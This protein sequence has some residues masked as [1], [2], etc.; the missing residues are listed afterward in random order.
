MQDDKILILTGDDILSILTGRELEIIEI[1]QRAYETHAKGFSSVPH[2]T[3]LRF[4]EAPSS[5]IIA[6]PAFLGE[7]FQIAGM[8]WIASFPGNR[9]TGLDRA[10]AVLI[11]N[12]TVTG[13]PLA[14]IEGSVISAKRTAASAALA[15]RHLHR[16][17]KGSSVGLI[18]CGPINLEVARFILTDHPGISRL[19]VFDTDTE[20]ARQF[21]EKA[22][23]LSGQLE[24]RVTADLETVLRG[25]SLISLATTA[26]EPH[27]SDL[28][29]CAPGTTIL[30]ISL[31]DLAPQVILTC[32]N[33]VDDISHV[34]R[35]QTSLHLAELQTGNR[36]FIRCTLGDVLLGT[37]DPPD[38]ESKVIFSPFG[39]GIL[40]IA[41][42]KVVCDIADRQGR[43]IAISSFLPDPW[44]RRQESITAAS[45]RTR[46]RS[47]TAHASILKGGK[48]WRR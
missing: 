34:C 38:A 33:V 30:H 29:S 43:G 11:L 40:D 35:A 45:H 21:K 19:L 8:K 22:E 28:S 41:L 27:I 48:R 15:A 17:Q 5:R 32:D 46:D 47:S 9:S 36:S 16:W 39:L 10:S 42:G 18:G 6:L 24:I 7:D 13:R 4:V 20:R 37:A 44:T 3:F 2:S 25:C 26:I 14:M 12:S 1:V 31:R 23:D